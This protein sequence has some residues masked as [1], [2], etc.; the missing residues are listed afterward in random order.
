MNY[1]IIRSNRKTIAAEIK[2]GELIIRAPLFA[3][4]RDI[5]SFIK[6]KD[7]WIKKHL[8]ESQKKQKEIDSLHKLS[9]EEIQTLTDRAKQA[10]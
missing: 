8:A 10:K 2:K 5:Q 6:K 1:E 9:S 3:T 4:N 7:R